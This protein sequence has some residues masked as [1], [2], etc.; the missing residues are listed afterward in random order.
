MALVPSASTDVYKQTNKQERETRL[1]PT[2]YS[3]ALIHEKSNF[4]VQT[5]FSLFSPSN[6]VPLSPSPSIHLL[7]P[8]SSYPWLPMVVSLF[9]AHLFLE[10]TSPITFPPSPFRCHWSLRS[11]RLHWWRRSKAYKLCME[12]Y[13]LSTLNDH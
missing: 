8:S 6:F 13:H 4:K 5:L 9:L 12:L 3:Q 7:L 2:Y 1:R 10:V 11:K